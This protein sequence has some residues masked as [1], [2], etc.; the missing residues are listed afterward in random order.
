MQYKQ[1]IGNAKWIIICK[2][3]QS[4]LQLVIG[5]L[6]ARYL[7]PS[8]YGYISYATSLVAFALP[9][10]RLG[11]DA[12][13]VHELVSEPEKEGEIMGTSLAMNIVSSFMCMIG[14]SAFATVANYGEENGHI[15][16]LVCVLYSISIFFTATEMIQYWFQ[17]KLLSKY[18]S[19]LM[20]VA[21][22][23]AT[24]YRVL[25]LILGEGVY[26]FALTN[27]LD[28]G[29]IGIGLIILYKRMGSQKFSFSWSRGKKMI[30]R[31][32]YYILS[33]MMIM[34]IQNTDHL[35]ITGIID[36]AENGIYAAAITIATMAQ[37]VYMAII[38]SFRPFILENKKKGSAEYEKNLSRLYCIIIYM[39]VLQ[40]IVFTIFAPLIV[41]ILY[42]AD[43]AGTVPVLQILVWYISFAIMGTVRNIYLLAEHMEKYLWRIN[44]IGALFN[45]I[46]NAV[47]IP[48][49]GACGAAFASFL[50]QLFTNFILG[51]IIKPLRENNRLILIGCNPVFL[52]RESRSIINVIRKK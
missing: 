24:S 51:F 46:L 15:I 35:M 9:I 13:L 10:M 3:I 22:V 52:F 7:G 37:F 5:M 28:F 18:S 34:I 1:V 36:S 41:N 27:S 14:V 8:N 11:F 23:V 25:L 39:A 49:W 31:G 2:I 6:C 29:I 50:T 12:I 43:Y 38:D 40:G 47:M 33:S 42:G 20:L 44:L 19:L 26:W 21:Y 4:L 45:V 16:I 32:K 30:S 48:Y 17:Y